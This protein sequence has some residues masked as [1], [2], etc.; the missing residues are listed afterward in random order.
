MLPHAL[1]YVRLMLHE[2]EP[3]AS[4]LVNDA[5]LDPALLGVNCRRLSDGRTSLHCAIAAN[6]ADLAVELLSR[7]A[8]ATLRYTTLPG[9][10]SLST[11]THTLRP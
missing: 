1:Q 11:H 8:D 6:H 5:G 4:V 2:V 7:G 3:N 10:L 9:A